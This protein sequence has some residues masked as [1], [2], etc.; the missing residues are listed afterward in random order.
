[1]FLPVSIRF[2]RPIS[3]QFMVLVRV[4]TTIISAVANPLGIDAQVGIRTGKLSLRTYP[5]RTFFLI[6]PVRAVSIAITLPTFMNAIGWRFASKLV[7]I[8]IQVTKEFVRFVFAV[9]I[10]VTEFGL[11]NAFSVRACSFRFG[12]IAILVKAMQFVRVISAVIII[13]APPTSRNAPMIVALEIG[14][15]AFL[16]RIVNTLIRFVFVVFAIGFSVAF[17]IDGNTFA[18]GAPKLIRETSS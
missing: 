9:I 4:I 18:C 14:V 15:I 11:V 1:M 13:I 10:S 6:T 8:A 17:P 7:G 12:T 5:R 3:A 2:T 16:D